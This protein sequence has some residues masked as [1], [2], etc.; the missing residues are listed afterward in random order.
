MAKR[1]YYE[2]LFKVNEN[3]S[4]RTW[5]I[6]REFIDYKNKKCASKIPATIEVNYKMLKTKSVDFLD[7]LSKYF[8]NVGANMYKNFS[9][10]H[11]KLTIHVKCCSKSFMFHEVTVGEINSCINNLKNRSTPELNGINSKFIKMSEVYFATFLATFFNKCIAQSVFPKNFKT[12]VITPI[13]KTTT[14][15]SMNDFRLISLCLYVQK[16]SKK[17]LQ[18][19]D[20]IYKIF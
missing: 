3:D 7:E 19:N 14:R 6:R 20:E 17:L 18:E 13:P 16:Y 4:Y 12:A 8:A 10:N 5:S 1:S 11:S 9:S 2:N 15:K